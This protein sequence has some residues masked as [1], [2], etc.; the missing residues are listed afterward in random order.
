MGLI[1][2]LEA[3]NEIYNTIMAEIKNAYNGTKP[4]T[5]YNLGD[6]IVVLGN[7]PSQNLFLK[8]RNDFMEYDVVCVNSF[9]QYSE[10]EFFEIKPRYYCAVDSVLFDEEVARK[11][12]KREMEEYVGIR[13]VLEKV[14][15][16]LSIVTWNTNEF[17]VDNSYIDEIKISRNVCSEMD[18]DRRKKL[19]LKNRAM[20]KTETVATVALFFS[21]VFGYKEVALFGVDHDD[22]KNVEF[23]D[24]DEIYTYAWHAYDKDKPAVNKIRGGMGSHFIY[25]IFEGYMWIFK[26]YLE[27]QRLAESVQCHIINYNCKSYIDA[28]EKS[29]KYQ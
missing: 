1:K 5:P 2:S 8:N 20:I 26:E 17:K 13:K 27:L 29:R 12:G 18:F 25:E 19:Y 16:K 3:L 22:F 28:F 4:T 7:G 11:I 14:D 9:P 24:S 23:D 15:W 6:K 10:K 21:I